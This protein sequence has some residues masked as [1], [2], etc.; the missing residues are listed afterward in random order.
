MLNRR[1][2]LVS[3]SLLLL[4]G[5]HKKTPDGTASTDEKN[6]KL[7]MSDI[8]FSGELVPII[9]QQM[10]AQGYTLDWVVINDIIQPNEMVDAG[11]AD[12]NS[13][14]HE[15][16]F[17]QFV[18]DHGL[19]NIERGFYTS[20]MP[21]GL[22][23]KKYKTLSDLPDGALF[24]IPVDPANNGRAL[25]MLQEHGLLTLKP[26]VD[27]VH[28]SLDDITA[29]P[30]NFKFLQVDQQ[31]LQ[32]TYQDVDVAFLF[33]LYAIKLGLD[34]IKDALAL[35]SQDSS[36]SP[37]RGIVA[38]TKG[39]AGTPKIAALEKAFHSDVVKAFD[40]QKYGNGI[41]FLDGQTGATQG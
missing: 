14:Q 24:G 34:P 8:G 39:L 29:N 4:D 6:V 28:A 27:V 26:G 25:F 13:F 35:E 32:R 5:C 21:S 10:A 7:I 37:Y 15:A 16:Y 20:Y 41:I 40:R 33:S 11:N 19:T 36:G 23:S 17:K 31:M 22:Y 38:V 12:A 30:H 9:K 1:S 18:K 3:A 2:L